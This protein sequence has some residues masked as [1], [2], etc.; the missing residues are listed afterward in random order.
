MI[1]PITLATD[2]LLKRGSKPSLTIATSGHLFYPTTI[3]IPTQDYGT[4]RTYNQSPEIK[5]TRSDNELILTEILI[6]WAKELF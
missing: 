4:G 6:F 1:K 3:L 2:G 5:K